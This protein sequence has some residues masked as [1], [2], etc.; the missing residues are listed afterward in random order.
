A[1]VK[2]RTLVEQ[3]SAITYT[4]AWRDDRYFV[5]YASPQIERMLGY[6]PKE[7]SDDPTRWYQWVHP[8]DR[9]AVIAENKRCEKS[10]EPYAMQYRMLRKDGATIWV[11]DSWVV[12]TDDRDEYRAFQGVVFDVTE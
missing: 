6:A 1:D 5:D 2:Y 7:W 8:G 9:E 3:I 11:E 10:G 12:V 4:W